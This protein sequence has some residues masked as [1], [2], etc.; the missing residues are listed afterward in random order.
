LEENNYYDADK[1]KND[2]IS[3]I[4]LGS[5]EIKNE[6]EEILNNVLSNHWKKSRN[7]SLSKIVMM[8]H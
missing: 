5:K 3:I 2:C 4:L 1:L 8:Y 7:P 6:L